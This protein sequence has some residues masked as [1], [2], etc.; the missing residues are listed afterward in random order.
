MM[1]YGIRLFTISSLIFGV[2]LPINAQPDSKTYVLKTRYFIYQDYD[3]SLSSYV[4]PC[5][6]RQVFDIGKGDFS[7]KANTCND[8]S[9]AFKQLVMTK[10][11]K[12]HSGCMLVYANNKQD[13]IGRCVL[14]DK[15]G[16]E[17][18]WSK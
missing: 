18:E 1:N 9:V 8:R 10:P 11:Y 2:A 13:N 6:L 14:L 16:Q 5:S 4:I 17:V 7:G 12:N 15:E 3:K